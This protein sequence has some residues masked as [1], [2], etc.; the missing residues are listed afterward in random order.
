M[1]ELEGCLC[2]CV[3]FVQKEKEKKKKTAWRVKVLKTEEGHLGKHIVH[4]KASGP[5]VLLGQGLR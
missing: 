4:N 5:A 3:C 2:R 1:F